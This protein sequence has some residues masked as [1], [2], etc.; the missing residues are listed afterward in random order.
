VREK[1]KW[2]ALFCDGAQPQI[3]VILNQL[4]DYLLKKQKNIIFGKYAAQCSMTQSVNDRGKMHSILHESFKSTA[5]RYGKSNVD[6][7]GIA[8]AGLKSLLQDNLN[9]EDFNCFWTCIQSA[10]TFLNK[11]FSESNVKSALEKSGIVQSN[12]NPKYVS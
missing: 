3:D 1:Y 7:P 2:I 9:T 11:A 4:N 10:G 8:W 12:K 6:P 5:F